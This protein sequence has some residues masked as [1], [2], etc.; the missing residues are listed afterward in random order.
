MGKGGDKVETAGV[1]W[2]SARPYINGVVVGI[3]VVRRKY[4]GFLAVVLAR[5]ALQC[6]TAV[7]R[8]NREPVRG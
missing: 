6:F 3:T 2:V 8:F 4:L 7:A 5:R 1:D